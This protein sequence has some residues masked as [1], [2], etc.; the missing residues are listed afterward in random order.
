[1]LCLLSESAR[2]STIPLDA[3]GNHKHRKHKKAFPWTHTLTARA[4]ADALWEIYGRGLIKLTTL[5]LQERTCGGKLITR[6]QC[7]H[8]SPNNPYSAKLFW[9][10]ATATTDCPHSVTDRHNHTYFKR[11]LCRCFGLL[12]IF[13]QQTHPRCLMV[14]ECPLMGPL[15]QSCYC[16]FLG[17]FVLR[18][19][20]VES[21]EEI[22]SKE[23]R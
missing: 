21:S 18:E 1:M 23:K 9:H 6:L 11:L 22:S 16:E 17:M 4:C 13:L 14:G 10:T 20:C 5:C 19:I 8:Q 7:L 12:C 2:G 3:R 15:L